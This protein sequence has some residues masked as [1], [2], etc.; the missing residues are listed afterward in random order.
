MSKSSA[1]L[2][3]VFE[4]AP[5]VNKLVGSAGSSKTAAS[6]ISVHVAGAVNKPGVLRVPENARIDDALK[7][8]GGA[9]KNADLNSLNLAQKLKD[10][11]QILLLE[12]GAAANT[13]A[14]NGTASTPGADVARNSGQSKRPLRPVNVNTASA[15]ELET[16]PGIGP[17][18]SANILARRAQKRF[19]SL[20]DLD[21]VKGLGPKKLEK[22]KPFV[23]F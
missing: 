13:V 2:P 22:L 18:T 11:E 17:K 6:M 1:A 10:G 3:P 15:A 20:D 14:T 19:R 7:L 12:R 16:L 9:K 23:L 8:A 21:E 4:D 5:Q